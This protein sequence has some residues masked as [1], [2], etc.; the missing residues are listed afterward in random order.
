MGGQRQQSTQPRV[1]GLLDKVDA[2]MFNDFRL[3]GSVDDQSTVVPKNR[4]SGAWNIGAQDAGFQIIKQRI[5]GHGGDMFAVQINGGN[6]WHQ[7]LPVGRLVLRASP[8]RFPTGVASWGR[9]Q[10][11][12]LLVQHPIGGRVGGPMHLVGS[13]G[14]I[15]AHIGGFSGV[16]KI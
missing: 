14:I 6:R 4:V 7:Q 16:Q 8:D 10:E 3:I 1:A 9:H 5:A 11:R 13:R 15:V 12:I 2:L